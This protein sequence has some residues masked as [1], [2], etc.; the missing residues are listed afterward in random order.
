MDAEGGLIKPYPKAPDRRAPL[1]TRS[2][3]ISLNAEGALTPRNSGPR[4]PLKR[5]K[6]F[7]DLALS[8][9]CAGRHVR[10]TKTPLTNI[11]FHRT[12]II[13]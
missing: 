11:N 4:Q 5:F 13:P 6:Q 2:R 12:V 10:K 9:D 7:M 3:S 8:G 1:K